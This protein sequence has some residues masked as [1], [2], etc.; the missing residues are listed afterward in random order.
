MLSHVFWSSHRDCRQKEQDM[1]GRK[2]HQL[3]FRYSEFGE[4]LQPGLRCRI[5]LNIPACRHT[6]QASLGDWLRLSV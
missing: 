4:L 2:I 3:K 6:L 1:E 5:F